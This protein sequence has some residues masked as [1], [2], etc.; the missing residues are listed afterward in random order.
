MKVPRNRC[1]RPTFYFWI[2]MVLVL[3]ARIEGFRSTRIANVIPRRMSKT[4]RMVLTTPEDI[5]EQ[6]STQT[7]L[8]ELINES[9]RTSA[10]RPIIMQFDPSSSK[11]KRFIK[12]QC[13]SWVHLRV[14]FFILHLLFLSTLQFG[15]GGRELCLVKPQA[16]VSPRWSTLALCCFCWSAFLELWITSR[17]STYY[18]VKCCRSRHLL[19]H[20]LSINRMLFGESA[21]N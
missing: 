7:L 6:A 3:L 14:S 15:N 2:L 16:R 10:R 11:G 4:R 12:V 13:W 20:F 18:G 1:R 21:T 9:V 5:I 8:D 19:L 17:G